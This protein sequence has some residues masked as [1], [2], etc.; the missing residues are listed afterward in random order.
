AYSFLCP[1]SKRYLG[2][3]FC[4]LFRNENYYYFWGIKIKLWLYLK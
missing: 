2:Y 3:A 4:L 1:K